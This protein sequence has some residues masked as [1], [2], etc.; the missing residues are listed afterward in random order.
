MAD[1]LVVDDSAVDVALDALFT[2]AAHAT[3]NFGIDIG[4]YCRVTFTQ[5][6][7]E[8][9]NRKTDLHVTQQQRIRLS[10]CEAETRGYD[11]RTLCDPCDDWSAGY[12][13]QV[14]TLCPP[15]APGPVVLLFFEVFSASIAKSY[16]EV[17]SSPFARASL[18]ALT[19]RTCFM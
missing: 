5:D 7:N 8:T 9:V 6:W 11:P 13:P 10:P 3:L 16:A 12:A 14:T 4:P 18:Y 15:R 17:W 19:L 2:R 1:D